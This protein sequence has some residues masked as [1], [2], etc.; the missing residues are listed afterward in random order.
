MKNGIGVMHYL[1]ENKRYEGNYK[2]DK[3]NGY[4]EFITFDDNKIIEKGIFEDNN[5]IKNL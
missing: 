3:K 2:N 5:L 4:G 1:S